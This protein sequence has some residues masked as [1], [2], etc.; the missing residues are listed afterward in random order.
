MT[1]RKFGKLPKTEDGRTL[2]MARYSI[3]LAPPPLSFDN[4]SRVYANLKTTNTSKLF[5]IDGNDK[6][7]DCVM[8]G[9]A[10]FVTHWNGLIGKEIIPSSC[11]VIKQYKKL[12]GGI[13]SGLNML[14]TLKIWRNESFFS[15]QIIAFVEIDPRN[16]IHV[17]QSIQLF[18]GVYLGFRVQEN[19][20][21]DFD[22]H[23]IW[24]PG[25]L[26]NGGHCIDALNYDQDKITN[27]TWGD[28]Q[29]GTW[30]WW[31]ETVDECY[32]II[33]PQAKDPTFA[34]GFDYDLLMSDLA[35]VSK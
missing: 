1:T 28:R 29:D 30:A 10:H 31:D 21:S 2:Q 18:G 23:K 24:T 27:L 19:A 7:G 35:H 15:D 22:I 14:E 12:T 25:I 6:Y 33:P 17:Q 16:H 5:P 4:L 32:A 20:I 26:T 3:E 13:D 9:A 34:P 8:A 11:S